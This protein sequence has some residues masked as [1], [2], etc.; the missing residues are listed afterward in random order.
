MNAWMISLA[1]CSILPFD[2]YPSYPC[3]NRA[4]PCHLLSKEVNHPY[5]FP[6]EAPWTDDYHEL[7]ALRTRHNPD[8]DDHSRY[9]CEEN[10]L[11]LE[12]ALFFC[13]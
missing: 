8:E 10:I 12:D 7:K 3:V 4:N 9:W 13:V 1:V 5:M 11:E 2:P 6:D